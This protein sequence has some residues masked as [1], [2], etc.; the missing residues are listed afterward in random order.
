MSTGLPVIATNFSGNTH[1]MTKDNSLLLK[2]EGME[3]IKEG[4]FRG[5]FW[6]TPSVTHLRQLMRYLCI[7]FI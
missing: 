7:F 6:A 3:E 2:I 1:F 4:A 5:H